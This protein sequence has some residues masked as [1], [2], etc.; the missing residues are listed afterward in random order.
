MG[1]EMKKVRCRCRT[2]M[3]FAR[4]GGSGSKSVSY[5]K[6]CPIHDKEEKGKSD[7]RGESRKEVI[8]YGKRKSV[9]YLSG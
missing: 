8:G 4:Y 9:S 1:D 3:K 2:N 5:W 7:T 6:P